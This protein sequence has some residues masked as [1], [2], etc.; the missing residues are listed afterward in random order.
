M[1]QF[2]QCVDM[3]AL[4]NHSKVLCDTNTKGLDMLVKSKICCKFDSVNLHPFS[5]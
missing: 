4:E 2:A 3:G 5:R 1:A